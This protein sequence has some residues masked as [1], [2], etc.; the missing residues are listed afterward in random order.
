MFVHN[1]SPS[2]FQVSFDRSGLEGAQSPADPLV[3]LVLSSIQASA[4]FLYQV[5]PTGT[6]LILKQAQGSVPASSIGRLAVEYSGDQ[7]QTLRGLQTILD[8]EP[9][10]DPVFEK[11]PEVL[12]YRFGRL[13]VAPLSNG[14]R[15]L[16]LLTV[17]RI[18]SDAF[19]AGSTERIRALAEAIGASFG[20]ESLKTKLRLLSSELSVAGERISELERKLEERKLI[21]RAKGI[22]QQQGATEEDAF[23]SIRHTSRQRRV[24]MAEVAREIIAAQQNALR[25][26]A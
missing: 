15:L 25:M 4:L 26:S 1:S 5:D 2:R 21:E 16:G 19:D 13:L 14:E 10:G 6:R 20:N 7:A 3:D 12:Q 11:F 24:L 23:L 22:L 18:G 9:L 8:I 17:G